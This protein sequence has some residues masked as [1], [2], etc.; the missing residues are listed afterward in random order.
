V[1]TT[2]A[3]SGGAVPR[4]AN[5]RRSAWRGPLRFWARRLGIYLLTTWGA[6]TVTFL[7]LRLIPGDPVTVFAERLL[8]TGGATIE[9]TQEMIEH[10]RQTLGLDGTLWEQYWRYLYNVVLRQDFGLSFIAFPTPAQDLIRR[11]MP[12]TIVLLGVAVLISW[13]VGVL[14]GALA[15]WYRGSLLSNALTNIGLVVSHIPFFFLSFLLLL[16]FGYGLA[17][18]PTRGAYSVNTPPGLS[19]DFIL[20]AA[21]HAILPAGSLVLV[22]VFSWLLSTR[23]V[24]IGVLG[25]DYLLF[26]E[27][28][29]LPPS[30]ILLRH[31]LRNALLPQLTALGMT[32][33]F[34]VNGSY[35]VEWV[36]AYPGVG[37]LFVQAAG[38]KDL[39]VMQGV[40]L[41]SIIAV[42]TANLLVD[43]LLP[44]LDPRIRQ[45]SRGK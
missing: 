25:E 16:A 15:A 28:K 23:A 10:Y 14:V 33:G 45:G 11:A 31:A 7:F 27:A 29:G 44:F 20:S 26:A 30:R 39:N 32:L 35:L 1:A 24:M 40:M 38:L 2:A 36:F 42:L 6:F 22:S 8:D 18:L 37:T 4:L 34:V 3:Q 9:V 41:M 5:T 13:G 19:L 12:W 43:L 17:L 21:R